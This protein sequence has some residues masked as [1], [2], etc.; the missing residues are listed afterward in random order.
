MP[1]TGLAGMLKGVKITRLALRASVAAPDRAGSRTRRTAWRVGMAALILAAGLGFSSPAKAE[2]FIIPPETIGLFTGLAVTTITL[3]TLSIVAQTRPR[4][5]YG[6]LPDGWLAVQYATAGTHL[7]AGFIGLALTQGSDGDAVIAA[8]L[9][10]LTVG[11]FWT[12]MAISNSVKRRPK[13][14]PSVQPVV[15]AAN[16]DLDRR[17]RRSV[18]GD[19]GWIF[20]VAGRF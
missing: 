19:D 10:P 8:S 13:P 2:S 4:D 20:G 14:P 15:F 6:R 17:V 5:E 16:A 7:T 18:A 9:P 11:L 1:S 3:N 12:G